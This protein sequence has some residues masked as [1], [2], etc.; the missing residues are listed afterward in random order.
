MVFSW[1]SH[2]VLMEL[3]CCS[4]GALI[5]F[6]WCSHG[7]LMVF[8][9]NS[10]CLSPQRETLLRQLETNQLDMDAT[11]E[12]LCVQQETEDQ[13]YEMYVPLPPLPSTCHP[14]LAPHLT[15]TVVFRNKER[16]RTDRRCRGGGCVFS[17]LIPWSYTDLG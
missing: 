5:V 9:W 8:S 6:S 1:S 7:A 10:V 2:G 14:K 11:L 17:H 13:N 12:E 15:S 3:S 16:R 4:H